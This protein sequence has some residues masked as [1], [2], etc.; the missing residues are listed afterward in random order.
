M[1][2]WREAVKVLNI[3]DAA[4]IG[5]HAMLFIGNNPRERAWSASEV[6]KALVVSE[7]HLS[8]VLQRLTRQR[9]LASKRGPHG[10]FVLARDPAVVSILD[11]LEAI[12]GPLEPPGCLLGHALCPANACIMGD[13]LHRTY[14][15]VH[16][17]LSKTL[18]SDVTG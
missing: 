7:A 4:N 6:G 1:N 14:A 18:L 2:W 10:G 11:I 3:S 17:H 5:I 12:D 16:S 8:K 13:V 15:L 9:F